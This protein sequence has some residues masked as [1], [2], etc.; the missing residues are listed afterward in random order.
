MTSRLLILLNNPDRH[1]FF[2]VMDSYP[3][4]VITTRKSKGLRIC[5][6]PTTTTTIIIIAT[7]K[8]F[9]IYPRQIYLESISSKYLTA[10][11]LRYTIATQLPWLQTY[12]IIAL[13]LNFNNTN[14]NNLL[15]VVC[16]PT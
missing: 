12:N 1:D 11:N 4:G 5:A 8:A 10:N 16:S 9:A 14:E 3:N 15:I 7:S 13:S 2:S 6:R